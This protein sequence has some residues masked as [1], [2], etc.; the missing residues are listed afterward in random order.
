MRH[1]QIG[2][3]RVFRRTALSLAALGALLT[4]GSP[5]YGQ[6]QDPPKKEEPPRPVER[7]GRDPLNLEDDVIDQTQVIKTGFVL[8]INVAGET[9]PSD[10]YFVDSTGS[11]VMKY[12]GIPISVTVSK[13]PPKIAADEIAKAFK[14]YLNNPVVTVS[15]LQVP[16]S[17]VFINAPASVL[18]NRG[19]AI[20]K[21][22][23]TTLLQIITL[24]E[25]SELAD[26]SNIKITRTDKEGKKTTFTANLKSFLESDNPDEKDNPLLQA[27]DQISVSSL[28]RNIANIP[29]G[30]FVYVGGEVIKNLEKIPYHDKPAMTVIE[31]L[32]Q[33]GGTSLL[34]DRKRVQVRRAGSKTPLIVDLDLV[35][36][37]DETNNIELK[38]GDSIIVPRLAMTHYYY[39]NGGFAK[40]GKFPYDHNMTLTQAVMEN[41]GPVPY[42]KVKDGIIIRHL[43]P[44]GDPAKTLNI[45]FNLDSILK[46]KKPDIAVLPG[47]SIYVPSGAPPTRQPLD[48]LGFIG[49]ASQVVNLYNQLIGRGF[50]FGN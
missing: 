46:R 19:Q 6:A 12:Q 39:I 31:A 25:Y 14:K 35:D 5:S 36:S 17:T 50:G 24:A 8:R 42:A 49:A 38:P 32:T 16:R 26:F 18:R 33:V 37:G 40:T 21:Q 23:D 2:F 11:V 29:L 4:L 27:K 48:F 9:E 44:D 34:A 30:S 1:W 13:F 20:I 47:D 41:G 43:N 45:P 7:P 28:G 22:G 15:I 10:T 3:Y